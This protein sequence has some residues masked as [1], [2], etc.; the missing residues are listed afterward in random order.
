MNNHLYQRSPFC[1]AYLATLHLQTMI[2]EGVI[3]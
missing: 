1:V 2:P 3:F